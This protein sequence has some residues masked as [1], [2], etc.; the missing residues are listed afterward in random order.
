MLQINVRY[1]A[2]NP[3]RLQCRRFKYA[4]TRVPLHFPMFRL[5]VLS[6]VLSVLGFQ[7]WFGMKVYIVL[8]HPNGIGGTAQDL[9]DIVH[10][11]FL[12]QERAEDFVRGMVGYVNGYESHRLFFAKGKAKEKNGTIHFQIVEKD[13]L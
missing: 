11:V 13:T 2:K 10:A 3:L 4:E 9:H 6:I 7:E 5:L 1:Q 12:D 8:E